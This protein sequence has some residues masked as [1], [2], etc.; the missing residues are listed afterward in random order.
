MAGGG[1]TAKINCTLLTL[2]WAGATLTKCQAEGGPQNLARFG[3]TGL[4][5]WGVWQVE[6]K[7]T[8]PILAKGFGP[9]AGG[10]KILIVGVK[11]RHE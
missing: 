2:E 7:S 1:S 5:P 4:G 10:S 8:R 3:F 11:Q 6:E 9:G